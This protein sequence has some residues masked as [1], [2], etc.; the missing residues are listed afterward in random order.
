M[1]L[2]KRATVALP[3]LRR[4]SAE[5][6]H[7]RASGDPPAASAIFHG[8]LRSARLLLRLDQMPFS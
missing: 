4:M 7:G 5:R 8:E 3:P 1:L 2:C 6:A